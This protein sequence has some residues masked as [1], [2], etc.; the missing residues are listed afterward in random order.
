MFLNYDF[1]DQNRNLSGT[2]R[3]P[4]ADNDDKILRTHF[5]IF[6]AQYFINYNWGL[7]LEVPFASRYFRTRDD[8]GNIVDRNWNALGDIR[9]NG[10]YTGFSDDLSTGVTFGLKLPTGDFKHDAD[11]ID[12]DSQIGTGSTD[13]LLGGFHRQAFHFNHRFKWFAQA[14]L[15]VP[16]LEMDHYRPGVEVDAASG[17]YYEGWSVGD[18]KISPVAQIIGSWRARDAGANSAHPVASG[19]ER[20]LL[21]PGI[22]FHWR[23]V[24]VYGDVALPVYERVTGNQLVSSAMFK[25]IVSYHF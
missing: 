17:I 16:V 1:Q 3:A 2:S 19:Y 24:S 21:S 5:A 14:N 11:V 4:A 10:V 13:I 22:E 7:Q 25:L 8:A 15:D 23:S 9:I 12:R 6:G 20:V 18:L